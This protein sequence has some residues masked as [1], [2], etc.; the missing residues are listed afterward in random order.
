[1]GET[2]NEIARILHVGFVEMEKE[3]CTKRNKIGR[4]FAN[5][6]WHSNRKKRKN[7][8]NNNNNNN[9]AEMP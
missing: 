9:N 6:E 4:T 1:M 3:K 8:N 2:E 7:I 5:E